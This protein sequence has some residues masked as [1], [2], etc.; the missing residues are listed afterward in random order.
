MPHLPQVTLDTTLADLYALSASQSPSSKTVALVLCA[1]N[2]E[3]APTS[4]L[5]RN[6]KF[7]YQDSTF[8][9]TPADKSLQHHR[10]I[11]RSVAVKYLSLVPQHDAFAAG[12]MTVILFSLDGPG[13]KH[14]A[15][16]KDEAQRTVSS[17]IQPQRPK[18]LFFPGPEQIVLESN[19]I[20][21]L[22]AKMEFDGLEGFPVAVSLETHY[23]LNSKA[24]ICSSGLPR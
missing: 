15:R 8:S 12:N 14:S 7:L 6:T 23:F 10:E 5:A 24:A 1:A 22:A 19:G 20:D 3:I 16:S 18:L 11:Q 17:L 2:S 4:M 9:T 21:V 13:K